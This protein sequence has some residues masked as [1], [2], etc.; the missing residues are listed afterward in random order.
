MFHKFLYTCVLKGKTFK[1]TSIKSVKSEQNRTKNSNNNKKTSFKGG[2]DNLIRAWQV[3]DN[4]RALQFTVEDMLGTNIP[5]TYKGAMAGYKYT[6]EVNVPALLQEAI[7][8]FLTGPTMCAVPI[9]VLALAKKSMGR[10]S[11]THAENIR[12][13]SHLAQ[14]ATGKAENFKDSFYRTVAED[15]LKQTLKNND[16]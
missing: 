5:R 7:R 4:S 11:D 12:N 3:I 1:L 10:S 13:L 2:A 6:G 8:E 14:S 15:M 16:T 9:A